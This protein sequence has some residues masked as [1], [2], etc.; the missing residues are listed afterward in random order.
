MNFSLAYWDNDELLA[1]Q[2][3]DCNIDGLIVGFTKLVGKTAHLRQHLLVSF[4][5]DSFSKFMTRRMFS[6]VHFHFGIWFFMQIFSTMLFD[7]CRYFSHYKFLGEL[8]S[9]LVLNSI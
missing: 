6:E 9:L 3:V 2:A 5:S 8:F 7:L 4:G 1:L